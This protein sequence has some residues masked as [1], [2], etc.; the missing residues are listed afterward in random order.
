MPKK[1]GPGCRCC[2]CVCTDCSGSVPEFLFISLTGVT[3]GTCADCTDLNREWC[4]PC[5]GACEWELS[6]TTACYGNIT[7]RVQLVDTGGSYDLRFRITDD[8]SS[9]FGEWQTTLG[10]S[11]P[12]C[13]AWAAKALSIGTDT[14]GSCNFASS[15][16]EVS[17]NCNGACDPGD[18]SS[19]VCAGGAPAQFKAV[20]T[21]P[22]GL[23]CM[24]TQHPVTGTYFLPVGFCGNS[25]DFDV[26]GGSGACVSSCCYRTPT[27]VGVACPTTGIPAGTVTLQLKICQDSD[28]NYKLGVRLEYFQGLFN[29][30]T[31][32]WVHDYGATK[33]DCN[34]IAGLSVPFFGV[35]PGANN[36]QSIGASP[37]AVVTAA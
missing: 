17:A 25:F 30:Q 11:K 16:A 14:L 8:S 33:P 31:A 24:G 21:I 15:T 18:G 29:C 20:L 19:G 32:T 9:N 34:A 3:N 36:C 7:L 1:H 2:G 28:G 13:A 27:T 10:A 5:T 22:P 23:V 37:T 4:L 12:D 35:E 6:T 26:G